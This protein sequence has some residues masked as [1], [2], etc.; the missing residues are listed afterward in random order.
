MYYAVYWIIT[1]SMREETVPRN[2]FGKPVGKIRLCIP[3]RTS[4]G[5][6]KMDLKIDEISG[7]VV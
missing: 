5:N 1:Y 4:E 3:G 2:L 7:L 6:I